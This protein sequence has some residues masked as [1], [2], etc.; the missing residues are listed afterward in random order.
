MAKI[1]TASAPLESLI[2]FNGTLIIEV[3]LEVNVALCV[4]DVSS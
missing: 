1:L 4:R 3:A 2:I